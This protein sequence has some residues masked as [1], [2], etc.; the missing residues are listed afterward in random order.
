MKYAVDTIMNP[1]A[2]NIMIHLRATELPEVKIRNNYYRYDSTMNRQDYAKIFNFKKPTLGIVKDQG[3]NP[4]AAVG[5]DLQGIIDMFRFKRNASILAL[6]KRLIEQEQE[7]YVNN[8]FSKQFVRKITKLPAPELDSFMVHYRPDY[9]QLQMMNDLEL[10]YWIGKKF[11]QYKSARYNW[12][13]ALY[14]RREGN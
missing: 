12:R 14:R 11:E 1:E 8:R 4:G 9:A 2:F 3:Y 10:G 13:G 7:K 5:F 6:Q